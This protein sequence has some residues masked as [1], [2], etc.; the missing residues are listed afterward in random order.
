[1]DF[2]TTTW[3]EAFQGFLL[4]LQATRAPKTVKYYQTLLGSLI[5]WAESNSVPLEKFG[6]RQ[7]DTYLVFRSKA[8]L[9][10]LT[11]HHDAVCAKAFL[12]WC[13]RNDYVTVSLLSDY[14]VRHAPAPHKYSK[15]Y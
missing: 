15:S 14:E 10:Q 13:H 9:A 3:N 8:G 4:H 7:M 11:L 2:T 6:K 1:M 12:R 5:H